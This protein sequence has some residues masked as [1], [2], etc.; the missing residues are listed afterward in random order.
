M[1]KVQSNVVGCKLFDYIHFLKIGF[2]EQIVKYLFIQVL[3]AVNLCHTNGI[4]HSDI[5]LENILLSNTL[6]LKL[7]DFGCAKEINENDFRQYKWSG[8]IKYSAPEVH[9]FSET[10][11]YDGVKNDIFSLGIMLFTLLFGF[12]PFAKPNIADPIYKLFLE[13]EYCTFWAKFE[14]TTQCSENFKDLFNRMVCFDP[15]ERINLDQIKN[16]PWLIEDDK[17][18]YLLNHEI[19]EKEFHRRKRIVDEKKRNI[20]VTL[21][22]DKKMC[23]KIIMSLIK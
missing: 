5:K 12:Y 10:L 15:K 23:K 21:E 16:H 18:N 11:G 3:E 19:F 7:I 4:I 1:D 8:I 17:D 14:Q 6:G 9:Y 13:E 22:K 2:C 20:G